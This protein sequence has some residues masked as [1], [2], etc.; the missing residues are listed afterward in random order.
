MITESDILIEY[1]IICSLIRLERVKM[2][3]ILGYLKFRRIIVNIVYTTIGRC[4]IIVK[5]TNICPSSNG[6][7]ISNKIYLTMKKA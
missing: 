2:K 6:V 3:I 1:L 5:G 4:G 7:D